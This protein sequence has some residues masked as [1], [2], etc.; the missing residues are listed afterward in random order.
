MRVPGPVKKRALSNLAFQLQREHRLACDRKTA[1]TIINQTEGM[2]DG[3]AVVHESLLNGLLVGERQVHFLHQAVHEYFVAL[4]LKDLALGVAGRPARVLVTKLTQAIGLERDI[5]DWAKDDWW[6]ES[7]VQLVGLV[8]NP[9]RLV[10]EV[11]A[12]NPWLAYWCMIE[13]QS[14][15]EKTKRMVEAKTVSLLKSATVKKRLQAVHELA[16]MENP[17]TVEH[18]EPIRITLRHGKR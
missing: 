7:L 14:V 6:A 17:R 16:R 18:L 12:A 15:N 9:D 4:R 13:G 8:E 2:S 5:R 3:G 10:Q 11:L 1:A